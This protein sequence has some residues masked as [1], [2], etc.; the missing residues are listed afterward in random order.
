MRPS[1][2]SGGLWRFDVE[3][4][5]FKRWRGFM[6]KLWFHRRKRLFP[7]KRFINYLLMSP[8]ERALSCGHKMIPVILHQRAGMPLLRRAP[9]LG[10]WLRLWATIL[11]WLLTSFWCQRWYSYCQRP[12][13]ASLPSR[14]EAQRRNQPTPPRRSAKGRR[15]RAFDMM[16]LPIAVEAGTIIRHRK[17]MMIYC[18]FELRYAAEHQLLLVSLFY[19]YKRCFIKYSR[20]Q[21]SRRSPILIRFSCSMRKTVLMEWRY[22]WAFLTIRSKMAIE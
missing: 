13:N 5:A 20:S 8:S 21:T 14:S 16:S 12:I 18:L 3:K 6:Y 17:S 1:L 11:K 19:D 2:I 22:S 7:W 15:R 9:S 4:H 10:K